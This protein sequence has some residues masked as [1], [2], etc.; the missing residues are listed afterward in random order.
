MKRK[1]K[2]RKEGIQ[3]LNIII[4]KKVFQARWQNNGCNNSTFSIVNLNNNYPI[5][6]NMVTILTL[7]H[8]S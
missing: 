7:L 8:K 2:E 3:T 5:K 6:K 4:R 1:R